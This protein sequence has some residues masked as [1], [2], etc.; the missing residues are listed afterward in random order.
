LPTSTNSEPPDQVGKKRILLVD[1]H[2]IF[3]HGLSQLI[4]RQ[5]GLLV[6]G[7]A[8]SASDA[9]EQMRR[10]R[11]D[12]AIL[13]ITLRGTNGIELLKM[14]KAEM[15]RLP[16]IMLSMH[17]EILYAVRALKAGALGYV[18]KADGPK[19][20]FEAID[21]ALQGKLF[22]GPH[23]ADVLILQAIHGPES[24]S[25][26]PVD[27]L[28]DRELEVLTMIGRGHPTRSVA[29]EL[30]LSIKTIETHRSH[31]KE[32][33]GFADGNDLVRFAIEWVA[34]QELR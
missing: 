1:D 4:D 7:H 26:S 3:R 25:A 17:D 9:L 16:M 19:P 14:M 30:N 32:K 18:M 33:L 23:L 13:D 12:L 10:L 8:D 20:L 22:V 21:R 24:A 2:P 34:Q 5:P 6:C 29:Q 15:P 31:I 11:P 28:S 27:R